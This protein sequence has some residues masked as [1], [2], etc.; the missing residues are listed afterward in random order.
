[1]KIKLC[2]IIMA[3]SMICSSLAI[4]ETS[5][6]GGSSTSVL[7]LWYDEP[8]K[9][10]AMDTLPIGN[11]KM[12]AMI[13]GDPQKERIQFNEDSLWLGDE[14]ATG[15]YQNFGHLYI[16]FGETAAHRKVKISDPSNHHTS[17][18][19]QVD[20]A[21]DL[22]ST[23]KWCMEYESKPAIAQLAFANKQHDPITSYAMT[24]ANRL[25]MQT[26]KDGN[27]IHA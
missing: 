25:S 10:F 15:C 5:R 21:F 22:S 23:T 16:T 13:F 9:N 3:A 4:A 11:G 27:P 7:R 12:G 2:S 1:M 18:G 24:S 26:S 14:E 8:A 20:S 6:S 19:E 17:E